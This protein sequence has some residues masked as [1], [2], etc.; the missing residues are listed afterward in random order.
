[1]GPATLDELERK[2][3]NKSFKYLEKAFLFTSLLNSLLQVI[4]WV[5]DRRCQNYFVSKH[6]QSALPD[7]LKPDWLASNIIVLIAYP[8]HYYFVVHR[9]PDYKCTTV[10][11]TSLIHPR[12]LLWHTLSSNPNIAIFVFSTPSTYTI[13][14]S[15]KLHKK[16]WYEE[17]CIQTTDH[18]I[19]LV[20]VDRT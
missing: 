16:R 17:K 8:R 13:N 12:D 5:R 1:M 10:Y 15:L 6:I 19:V 3:K 2:N 7:S 4:D 18:M 20:Y 9:V 14:I 11:N